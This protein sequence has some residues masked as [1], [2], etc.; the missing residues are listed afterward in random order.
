MKPKASQA[1]GSSVQRR[2]ASAYRRT[3]HETLVARWWLGGS[4]TCG[5]C[6]GVYAY[7]LEYRCCDCDRALCPNCATLRSQGQCVCPECDHC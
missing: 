6:H 5:F 2:S 7:E 4:E 3:R 1:R